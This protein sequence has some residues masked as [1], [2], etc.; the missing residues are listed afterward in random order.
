[1]QRTM[2]LPM[3]YSFKEIHSLNLLSD[4]PEY[5]KRFN[6]PVDLKIMA[7]A[8]ITI[9]VIAMACAI[10]FKVDKIVPAQGILETKAK[11]FHVRNSEAGFIESIYVTDGAI[12]AQGDALV[13]L[14]TEMLDLE[15][16]RLAQQLGN[17][18]R[19]VWTDY[20]QIQDWLS[21]ETLA[22]LSNSIQ[23]VPDAVKGAG[24]HEYLIDSLPN[25]LALIGQNIAGLE[26]RK[27]AINNQL[28]IATELFELEQTEF[29]RLTRLR[30]QGIESQNNVDTQKGILFS[31]RSGLQERD[32]DLKNTANEIKKLNLE[33]VNIQNDFVLD[34]LVRLQNE[35]DQYQQTRSLLASQERKRTDMTIRAPFPAIVDQVLARGKHE[36]IEA[37]SILTILRPKFD[38]NDLQIEIQ[39]PSNYAI[40]VEP[41]ME[42]RASSLG[43]NPEDHGRIHGVVGF[44]SESS[45]VVN[46]VRIYRMTGSITELDVKTPETF[47]RPGLQLSVEIKAGQRRLINYLFDPFT[48]YFKNALSE[49]S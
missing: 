43:N 19:S 27:S 40:W 35:L 5:A 38:E 39:I 9:L 3:E 45:E 20:Y 18:S 14:D 22:S 10:I 17:I 13:T 48:K 16:N 11:L 49:P 1:M 37:G 4:N 36:V 25:K 30:K 26:T 44:V 24:Y 2:G 8:I 31:L 7:S 28:D 6:T 42:F 21:A 29:E 33:S 15:I 32:A 23:E 34:R 47:L 12:V 46:G 41:G